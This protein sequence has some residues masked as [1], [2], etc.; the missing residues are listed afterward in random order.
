MVMRLSPPTTDDDTFIDAVVSERRR[1]PNNAY[2]TGIKTEWKLR[3]KAYADVSGDPGVLKP[4]ANVQ[5][6]KTKFL[7]LYLSPHADSVQKK[8][9]DVLRSRTLQLCPACG[10]DGTPNTL[11]HYL[12]KETYPE[13]SITPI[14]LSPMCDICQG[15]KKSKTVNATNERLFL[16]PYFDQ[17]TNVQVVTLKIGRPFEAPEDISIHPHLDLD[18][19]QSALVC[20]H[21]TELNITKRYYHFFKDEYARLQRLVSSTRSKGQSVRGNL[22]MFCENAMHKSMNSWLHVFYKG[23]LEDTDLMTYLESGPIRVHS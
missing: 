12:P 6:H 20:R 9:L 3:V 2:F 15:E 1:A 8:I 19:V 23:V 7:T 4:W 16:H 21:L 10:E 18:A 11:D 17:F 14:N 22:E 5:A 13:L